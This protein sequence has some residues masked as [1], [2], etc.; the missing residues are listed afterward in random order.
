MTTMIRVSPEAEAGLKPCA[1][2]V[3][4]TFGLPM[5]G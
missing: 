5:Q 2:S 3:A 1:T 4:Q